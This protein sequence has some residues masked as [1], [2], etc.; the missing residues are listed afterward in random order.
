MEQRA[1]RITNGGVAVS[2]EARLPDETRPL[3]GSRVHVVSTRLADLA[4][5]VERDVEMVSVARPFSPA[6]AALA[7]GLFAQRSEFSA[8]WIQSIENGDSAGRHLPVCSG[9]PVD[10]VLVD[11]IDA[12]VDALACL[13]GCR[14][15]GIRLAAL[16]RPMCPRFHVDRIP[17][18]MLMTLDGPGT[19]WIPHHRVDWAM[20]GDRDQKEPPLKVGCEY[21]ALEANAWSLMK[22]GDWDG[23]FPGVVHRSPWRPGDRLLVSF[24]PVFGDG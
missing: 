23:V 4:A 12:A 15:I 3:D 14:E 1:G 18:R 19:E 5:I 13:L 22:G 21:E 20:L 9:A 10:P 16:R 2:V 17:C 7:R 6:L 8:Q 11:E 24:D